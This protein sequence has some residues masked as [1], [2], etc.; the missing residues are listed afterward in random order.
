MLAANKRAE[1]RP[2]RRGVA[3]PAD[4]AGGDHRRP[5]AACSR[6]TSIGLPTSAASSSRR[7]PRSRSGSTGSSVIF[8]ISPA[9]R[10]ESLVP[11]RQWHDPTIV[12]RES[13]QRL[14]AATREH[15]LTVDLP[16]EMEPVL[17]DPVEIDQV[18]GEPRGERGEV[19]PRRRDS[20]DRC[21]R[22]RRAA[23]LRSRT[24]GRAFRAR[25]CHACSSRSTGRPT[26]ALSVAVASGWRWPAASSTPMEGASGPRT[27]RRGARFTFAIPAPRCWRTWRREPWARQP[28]SSS[29]RTTQRSGDR[30]RATLR[31]TGFGTEAVG[32]GE[33]A[34]RV[35]PSFHSDLVLLDLG[36]GHERAG[37][38]RPAPERT[39]TPIIVLS[40]REDGGRQGPGARSTGRTTT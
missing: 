26:R 40:V 3:R 7:S 21:R 6:T 4:A 30:V 2:A 10:A 5:P 18:V 17:L 13:L 19:L 8:S 39:T 33:E 1:E 27:E 20:R 32:T 31:R 34:L 11:A 36:A 14:G 37:G 9:S 25:S 12:V 29:S 15:Q 16:D 23:R 28:A 24:A 38:D 35:D 22:R